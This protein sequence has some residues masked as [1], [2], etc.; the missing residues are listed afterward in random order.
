MSRLR[1]AMI[2]LCVC[3]ACDFSS[4]NPAPQPDVPVEPGPACLTASTRDLSFG[5]VLAGQLKIGFAGFE[6]CDGEPARVDDVDVPDDGD[7]LLASR[8]YKTDGKVI[9]P[10]FPYV[11]GEGESLLVAVTYR[12]RASAD[13]LP[14]SRHLTVVAESRVTPDHPGTVSVG[15]NAQPVTACP[16]DTCGGPPDTQIGWPTA[17]C[18]TNTCY[19]LEQEDPAYRSDWRHDR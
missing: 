18:I 12:A 8:V 9:T 13:D 7:M 6:S 2:S 19:Y 5:L 15:L 16:D 4:P 10:L 17:N 14:V 3:P 1:L 11:L